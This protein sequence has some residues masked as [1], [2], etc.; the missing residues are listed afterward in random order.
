MKLCLPN[1]YDENINYPKENAKYFTGEK[2]G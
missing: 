2:K 1:R